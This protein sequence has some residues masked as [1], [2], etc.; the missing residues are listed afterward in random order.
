MQAMLITARAQKRK[1]MGNYAHQSNMCLLVDYIRKY[2]LM[3]RKD[4][5]PDEAH[6]PQ[7]RA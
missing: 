5:D 2:K 3:A 4:N 6:D 7:T 1:H